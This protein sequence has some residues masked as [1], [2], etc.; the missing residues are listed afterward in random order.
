MK[1]IKISLFGKQIYILVLLRTARKQETYGYT[2]RCSDGKYVVF[3]DY[4][5]RVL[6]WVR[7]ELKSL[8][9]QFNLGTFYIFSDKQGSYHAVCPDKV[10]YREFLHIMNES[11]TDMNYRIVPQKYGMRLWTLRIGKKGNRKPQIK[12]TVFAN[13]SRTQSTAH[14]NMLRK[15]F[16]LK[17][18]STV[19]QDNLTRIITHRYFV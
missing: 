14:L 10:T 16:N 3:L 6:A 11:S 15:V 12:E 1:R 18:P 5:K 19:K 8:Q 13:G 9:Q 7:E 2:N 17:V 4:D